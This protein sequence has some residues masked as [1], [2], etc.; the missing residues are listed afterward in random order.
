MEKNI[1]LWFQ[2]DVAHKLYEAESDEV[3]DEIDQLREQEKEDA[4]T[5]QTSSTM[6]TTDKER[7]EVMK[8]FDK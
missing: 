6:F 3:K 1:P 5:T 7:R 4:V 2:M 8:K